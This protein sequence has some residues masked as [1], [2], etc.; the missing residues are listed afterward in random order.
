MLLIIFQ[1]KNK[2]YFPYTNEFLKSSEQD[3]YISFWLSKFDLITYLYY[4]MQDDMKKIEGKLYSQ[5]CESKVL[6]RRSMSIEDDQKPNRK[7]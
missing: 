7:R 6:R 3:I 4:T 2:N 5:E 1:P